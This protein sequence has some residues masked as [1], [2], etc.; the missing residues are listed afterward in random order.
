MASSRNKRPQGF[1]I[2]PPERLKAITSLGGIVA[3]RLGKA[4]EWTPE[5]ARR[6][7]QKGVEARRKRRQSKN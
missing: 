5:E 7:S 2:L 6:A 3:H 1:Q 4:H